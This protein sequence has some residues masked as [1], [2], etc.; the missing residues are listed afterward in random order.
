MV[1]AIAA[2]A[3]STT[4]S[5]LRVGIGDDAA[6]WQPSRS[7]LSV[8]TTDALIEGVHFDRALADARSIGYR[9]LAANLSDIAAMGARPVLATIA[10]GVGPAPDV[11]WILDCY[12]GMADLAA[13]SK[14]AIAGGDITGSPSIL[15]SI[16]VI[17]EV[18]ASD[19]AL[20]SGARAG[21]VIA[22]TGAL[23]ASCAGLRALRQGAGGRAEWAGA[24]AAF[25]TPI[26]RLAEGRYLAR[27]VSV[28]AM[29]DL[30][31]GLSTDLARMAA[32]S[33]CAALI[34]NVP[35]DPQA[36]AIA[37]H[38]GEDPVSYALNGG[39]DYELLVAVAPRAFEHLSRRYGARF[40]RPLLRVGRLGEG[41]GVAVRNPDGVEALHPAGWDHL[42]RSHA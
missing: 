42:A 16:T 30:S 7:H 32:A 18:R 1:A 3:A 19:V 10:L 36:A 8:I 2:I 9:A 4:T 20:R 40:G 13:S 34:E 24:I 12:R 23:G 28:H 25:R 22:L 5:A 29:M 38:F 31:D 15:F 27:S 33:R 35:V 37:A 21:D 26:P 39:E 17:G 11:A 6:V 14:T 41:N